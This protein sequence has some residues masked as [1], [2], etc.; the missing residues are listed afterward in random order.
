M[1]TEYM[2]VCGG[3]GEVLGCTVCYA[4]VRCSV[5]DDDGPPRH[6]CYAMLC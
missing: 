1:L 4:A 3:G 6:E 2:C 5:C